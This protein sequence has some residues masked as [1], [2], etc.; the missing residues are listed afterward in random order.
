MSRKK[1][2]DEQD[3][4]IL[5]IL[6]NEGRVSNKDLANRIDLSEGPTNKRLHTLHEKKYIKEVQA[7]IDLDRLG[8]SY[9][10][11]VTCT[12]M[13]ENLKTLGQ[14][15]ATCPYVK[16]VYEMKE[17]SVTLGNERR[18]MIV[19]AARNEDQFVE[20]FGNLFRSL[21]FQFQF[22][23][24]EIGKVLKENLNIVLERPV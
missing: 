3:I 6:Q 21:D 8:Y 22:T 12:V 24:Y 1:E 14:V 5:N 23:V 18:L 11:M 17:R 4:K 15:L 7:K 2:I 19:G 16:M 10:V 20:I 9:N 13:E